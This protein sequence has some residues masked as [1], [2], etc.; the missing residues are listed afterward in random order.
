MEFPMI[1]IRK[2]GPHLKFRIPPFFFVNSFF[3]PH[4]N[5]SRDRAIF[6]NYTRRPDPR[7]AMKKKK[8]NSKIQKKTNKRKVTSGASISR[9]HPTCVYEQSIFT[10]VYSNMQKLAG[11]SLSPKCM[12]QLVCKF[13]AWKLEQFEI[14]WIIAGRTIG[15]CC[16]SFGLS[17]RV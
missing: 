3:L 10:A 17:D 7:G 2:G 15:F 1:F 14:V 8:K 6:V 9:S 13:C 11:K 5:T 16:E 12:W 4:Y